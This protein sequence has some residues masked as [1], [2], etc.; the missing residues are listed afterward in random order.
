M[1]SCIF[2]FL[3]CTSAFLYSCTCIYAFLHFCTSALLQF[4]IARLHFCMYAAL[5][6]CNSEFV[7]FMIM[8]CVSVVLFAG[9]LMI[10][11]FQAVAHAYAIIILRGVR[12]FQGIKFLGHTIIIINIII[13]ITTITT[14]IVLLL[15]VFINSY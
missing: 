15:L 3:H 9:R 12:G 6:F 2:A 11:C 10:W 4:C 8:C 5:H 7:V 1:H 13:T 14:T